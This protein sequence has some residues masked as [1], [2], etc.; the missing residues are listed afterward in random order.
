VEGD[1]VDEGFKIPNV[2]RGRE[3]RKCSVVQCCIVYF[4]P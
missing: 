2:N 4:F 1:S 3:K